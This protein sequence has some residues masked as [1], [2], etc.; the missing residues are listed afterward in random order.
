MLKINKKTILAII[1]IIFIIIGIIIFY[2]NNYNQTTTYEELIENDENTQ[3]NTLNTENKED[4]KKTNIVIYITGAVKKEGVFKL[5][6]N[7]RIADAIDIAGGLEE[8][9]D[10]KNINLALILEDG[11]KIYIPKEGEKMQNNM[12]ENNTDS[13]ENNNNE[14]NKA[15]SKSKKININKATQSELETIPGIGPSTALKI[16]EYRKNKGNFKKIEDIKNIKGI[17]ENKYIKMKDYII[18]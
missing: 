5:A 15:Q 18:V 7:S 16:I 2:V 11:T 10:I 17:G 3:E 4:N 6:E 1:I 13:N 8:G 9:A 12:E 14:K